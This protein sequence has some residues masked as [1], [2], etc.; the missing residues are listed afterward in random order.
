MTT[1]PTE[2]QPVETIEQRVARLEGAYPHLATKADL[3]H[4]EGVLKTEIARMDARIAEMESRF[5]K[6]T[7]G[8]IIGVSAV[9][10]A[11]ASVVIAV[12]A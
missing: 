1:Q 9:F 10:A 5:I 2:T 3:A 8:A 11:I 4:L 12:L 7:V 6:W